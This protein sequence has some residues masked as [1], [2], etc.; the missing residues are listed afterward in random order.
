MNACTAPSRLFETERIDWTPEKLEQRIEET[1][2]L[3][4]RIA[5]QPEDEDLVLIRTLLESDIAH[6]RRLLAEIEASGAE[7]RARGRASRSSG[8]ATRTGPRGRP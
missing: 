2:T 5:T 3:V 8:F 4:E 7:A 1:E 6:K